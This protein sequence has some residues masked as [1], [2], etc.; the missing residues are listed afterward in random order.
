MKT[1]LVRSPAKIN[2]CLNVVG[3]QPDGYHQLDMVILPLAMHDSMLFSELRKNEDNFV[4]VDDY[5]LGI[6]NY[7]LVSS[8]IDKLKKVK[9]FENSFRVSIHK[10]IP[11]QSGLGG[12]SSN[13]A[14]TLVAL[15]KYLKLGFTDD[16]LIE[17]GKPLG[18][19]IPFFIMGK[20]ARCRGIG[21]QLDFINIKNNYHVLIVKPSEGCSTKG[22][23]EVSDTMNLPTGNVETVIKALEEGDDDL[24]AASIF[25]AL[26]EP[27]MSLVPEIK[28]IKQKLFDM[29]LKI[30]QMTGSGSAVFALSTDLKQLKKVAKQLEEHDHYLVEITKVIK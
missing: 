20:P 2:I 3:K 27:A 21:E 16:E 23:Y 10:V 8:A 25:N 1:F 15:N 11:M 6:I 9:G 14:L 22:V 4:T 18:A 29:G 17:I 24:L 12:G 7:N 28:I 5:S 19:D 13:A 26:E 30:V